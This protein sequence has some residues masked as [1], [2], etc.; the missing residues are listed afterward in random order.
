MLA[1][2]YFVLIV[3]SKPMYIQLEASGCLALDL[4]PLTHIRSITVKSF[5]GI[6]AVYILFRS[7]E[8]S[9]LNVVQATTVEVINN[10]M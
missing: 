6:S 7:C 1:T 3:V 9:V 8:M 5:S 2:N 4:G 10:N